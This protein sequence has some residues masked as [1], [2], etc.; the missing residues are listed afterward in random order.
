MYVGAVLLPSRWQHSP[1]QYWL[2]A[3][4]I[5]GSPPFALEKGYELLLRSGVY[6]PRSCVVLRRTAKLNGECSNLQP[7]QFSAGAENG[8]TLNN[9]TSSPDHEGYIAPLASALKVEPV[10]SIAGIR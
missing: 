10:T 2:E 9:G 7:S 5:R 4:L 8:D 6:A 1:I 3:H